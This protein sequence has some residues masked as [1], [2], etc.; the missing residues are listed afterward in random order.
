MFKKKKQSIQLGAISSHKSLNTSPKL[1]QETNKEQASNILNILTTGTS[2]CTLWVSTTVLFLVEY[3][4]KNKHQPRCVSQATQP[5]NACK[6]ALPPKCA[7]GLAAFKY[8]VM[9]R[10]REDQLLENYRKGRR[11]EV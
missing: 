9:S 7:I 3:R 10:N 11:L 4:T 6:A 1:Q 2:R 8:H 5:L